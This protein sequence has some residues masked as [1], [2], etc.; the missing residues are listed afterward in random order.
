MSLHP[1]TIPEQDSNPTPTTP[2]SMKDDEISF[3][4]YTGSGS[5]DPGDTVSIPRSQSLV[6]SGRLQRTLQS[7]THISHSKSISDSFRQ[8][9]ASY[10][11]LPVS[12]G[13]PASVSP[14]YDV[15]RTLVPFVAAGLC[16]LE[17][18]WAQKSTKGCV[19]MD[20]AHC[21]LQH[22]SHS[23][24]WPLL[25]SF[26]VLCPSFHSVAQFFL[27]PVTFPW[28]LNIQ[29]PLF[30][31]YSISTCPASTPFLCPVAFSWALCIHFIPVSSS[32]PFMAA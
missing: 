1:L 31:V 17:H 10:K 5:L 4:C 21:P 27:C 15:P 11:Q 7:L 18:N 30:S 29:V 26:H 25:S 2:G 23:N 20:D 32:Q 16:S 24:L 3:S 22:C 19:P 9:S 12:P 8:C 13:G 14:G 28:A 6:N